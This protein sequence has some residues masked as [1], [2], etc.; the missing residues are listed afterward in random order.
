MYSGIKRSMEEPMT[1]AFV[2]GPVIT[3]TGQILEHA[4]V[5]VENDKIVKITNGDIN[6][7]PGATKIPLE[8]IESATRIAAEALCLENQ[9]GTI[10]EGKL[11]DLIVTGGNPLDD[12]GL[13]CNQENIHLVMQGGHLVKGSAA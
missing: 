2:N 6:I 3:G 1:T 8:A 4:T 9:I 12:I 10:E 5:L 13:L 11:A 7:P